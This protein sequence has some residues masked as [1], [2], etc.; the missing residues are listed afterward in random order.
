MKKPRFSVFGKISIILINNSK[1]AG[2]NP[3]KLG[4]RAILPLRVIQK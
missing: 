1:T 3:N 2:V 4:I